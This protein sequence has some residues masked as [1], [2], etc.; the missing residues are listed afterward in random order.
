MDIKFGNGKTKYGPGIQIDLSGEEVVR[1][2]YTYLAAHN[3]HID[4][5]VTITVNGGL[6]KNGGIYVDPSG[7][8]VA[9]GKGWSGRGLHY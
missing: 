7:K 4:G 2:I 5:P 6:C 3:I 1:A 9:N 8:V